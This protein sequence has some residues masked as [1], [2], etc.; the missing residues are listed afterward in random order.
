MK[1]FAIIEDQVVVNVIVAESLEIANEL[2]G[3]VCVEYTEENPAHIGLT[4]D[5]EFFE[6]PPIEVADVPA[7]SE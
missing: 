4:F 1:T 5:G 6:Q 2:T 7:D 3:Q